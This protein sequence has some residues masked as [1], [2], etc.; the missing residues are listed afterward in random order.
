MFGIGIVGYLLPVVIAV[1][2]AE[3]KD[4]VIGAFYLRHIAL[5]YL[6]SAGHGTAEAREIFDIDLFLFTDKT[7]K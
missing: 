4:H 6:F 5:D 1:V 7:D 3:F 2:A